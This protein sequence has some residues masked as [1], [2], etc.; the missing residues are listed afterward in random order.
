MTEIDPLRFVYLCL[1]EPSR[2]SMFA[3]FAR[4]LRGEKPLF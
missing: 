2:N 1:T 4:W 3:Q